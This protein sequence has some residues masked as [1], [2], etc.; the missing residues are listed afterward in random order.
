MQH[1]FKHGL[2]ELSCNFTIKQ[3]G[4][5]IIF[6]FFISIYSGPI[7]HSNKLLLMT[8]MHGR[9]NLLWKKSV[10]LLTM[11]QVIL[12]KENVLFIPCFIFSQ[13]LFG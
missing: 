7:F 12:K 1:E 9:M 13:R 4:I 11:L 8:R 10:E 2:F 3:P 6:L 5:W